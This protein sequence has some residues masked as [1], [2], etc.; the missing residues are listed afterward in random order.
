MKIAVIQASTQADKN[1][2]LTEIVKKVASPLG[3]E[4]VNFGV[5][6]DEANYSYTE[7]ALLISILLSSKSVDFI[8]TGCSSGQGMAL[9]CNTLPGVLCG[10]VQNP[11]DAFLFGR[12]NDGNAISFPLGLGYGWL[13]EL[14]LE[15][16][17]EK[18]FAGEFGIGYPAQDADRKVRETDQVKAFNKLVKRNISWL[19]KQLERPIVEKLIAKTDVLDYIMNMDRMSN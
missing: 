16:S 9:A 7:I 17:L 3:H 5:F 1:K 13:G 11:Q 4:I 12:I 15:Y 18:L 6:E 8:I 19:L 10:F 14:N 2:V